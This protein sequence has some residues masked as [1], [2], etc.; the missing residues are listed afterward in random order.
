MNQNNAAQHMLTG[1]EIRSI[2][3]EH[4]LDDEAVEDFA[5]AIESV[6]LSKL[7]A[8]VDDERAAFEAI[9]KRLGGDCTWRPGYGYVSSMTRLYQNFWQ[10]AHVARGSK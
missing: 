3:V 9:V 4:G 5:R 1:D 2:W 8:P 10:L 6:L 7:R